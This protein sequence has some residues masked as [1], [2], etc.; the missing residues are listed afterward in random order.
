V[1]TEFALYR[2]YQVQQHG[3]KEDEVRQDRKP[4]WPS[5]YLS[6]AICAELFTAKQ[7]T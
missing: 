5:E 1:E 2:D 4:E 6:S 7:I 3:D